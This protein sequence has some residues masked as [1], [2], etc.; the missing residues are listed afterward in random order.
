MRFRGWAGALAFVAAICG[1]AALAH[2]QPETTRRADPLIE[3]CFD[4]FAD[5][6]AIASAARAAGGT[7]VSDT[8][9]AD[10][11][12]S[13]ENPRHL[14]LWRAQRWTLGYSEGHLD[15]L[16]ARACYGAQ[17]SESASEFLTRIAER[18]PLF[19]LMAPTPGAYGEGVRETYAAQLHGGEALVIVEWAGDR[20]QASPFV[21]VVTFPRAQDRAQ[22]Q[23]VAPAS[24]L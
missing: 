13:I 12:A 4:G 22:D 3:A 9:F 23:A 21:T 8:S 7:Q 5:A 18:W 24:I 20:D 6:A 19:A 15:R 2:A 16:P 14:G 11:H 17:S 10:A 1:A